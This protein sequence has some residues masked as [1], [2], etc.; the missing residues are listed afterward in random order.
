M[1]LQIN[2]YTKTRLGSTVK[3]DDLMDLDSTENNGST[4]E[5][6][7]IKVSEFLNYVNG[8]ASNLYN[9]NGSLS[10]NRTISTGSF[11]TKFKGG[12]VVVSVDT[13]AAKN[14]FIAK[15]G[16]GAN[17]AELGYDDAAGSALLEL[18]DLASA[19]LYV[20]NRIF[21]FNN[22]MLYADTNSVG[23]NTDTP[24]AKL[25]IKG[26]GTSNSKALQVEDS[27]G[28]EV[29][30][31]LDNKEILFGSENGT[32]RANVEIYAGAA[33]EIR[34]YL[35][36]ATSNYA[37]LTYNRS[38]LGAAL[39]RTTGADQINYS[40]D[41]VGQQTNNAN[42][43]QIYVKNR[44][45][46][47]PNSSYAA[48][49]IRMAGNL[50]LKKTVSSNLETL[51]PNRLSLGADLSA[52][53]RDYNPS[54]DHFKILGIGSKGWML[55]VEG[56]T[57]YD[58]ES[59]ASK[60]VSAFYVNRLGIQFIKAVKGTAGEGVTYTDAATLKIDGAPQ[61]VVDSSFITN[62]YALDVASGDSKFG[63]DIKIVDSMDGVILKD[64]IN[65]NNYRIYTENGVLKTEI[66]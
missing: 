50:S 29:V 17:K 33:P 2:E 65:A 8:V 6:A 25:S 58:T 27:A 32:D 35:N 45:P 20:K 21:R 57:N 30:R 13:I 39:I 66:V 55:N 19:F 12:D 18:K 60:A 54:T 9:S 23:I 64:R 16:S 43:T 14:S 41:L 49:D 52:T 3:G 15:V 7:K 48:T 62:S 1:S 46:P 26:N 34:C 47:F 44:M 28:S 38:T 5:S 40:L 31:V 36:G 51:N 53:I 61:R 4:F 24:L 22:T 63:G 10:G 56:G 37:S 42:A 11:W 59:D